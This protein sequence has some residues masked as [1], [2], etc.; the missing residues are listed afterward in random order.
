M[1]ELVIRA[2]QRG[3]TPESIVQSFD[4]LS[5]PDVDAIAR[6]YL[7]SPSAIDAYLAT[8]DQRADAMR[9][10][11]EA[12]GMTA[13]DGKATQTEPSPSQTSGACI[14]SNIRKAW[15]MTWVPCGHSI[16][17]NSLIRLTDVWQVNRLAK[18]VTRRS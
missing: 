18:H 13:R 12:A 10:R 5:L 8:C 6:Y 11:L 14:A 1:L 4:T 7:E 15:P 16:V 17:Q 2:F 9:E 3:Q